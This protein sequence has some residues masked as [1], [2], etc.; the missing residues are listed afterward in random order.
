[1]AKGRILSATISESEKVADL[2][3]D[4]ARLLYTWLQPHADDLG[5][6]PRSARTIKAKVFPMRDDVTIDQVE[7]YLQAMIHGEG[8]HL[9][10]EH[11]I[12]GKQFLRILGFWEHQKLRKDRCPMTIIPNNLTGDSK[13][14]WDQAEALIRTLYTT[15]TKQVVTQLDTNGMS[16]VNHTD[17]TDNNLTQ[18]I[19]EV[20]GIEVNTS[21]VNLISAQKKFCAED[22]KQEEEPEHIRR[23]REFA[24]Q[25][26]EEQVFN[27]VVEKFGSD[28]RAYG[29]KSWLELIASGTFGE[30]EGGYQTSGYMPVG[31]RI[32]RGKVGV[33][34]ADGRIFYFSKN[35]IYK[36]A[37]TTSEKQRGMDLLRKTANGLKTTPGSSP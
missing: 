4:T 17:T 30:F 12:D 23:G 36:A 3:N 13:E 22:E 28:I 1:M 16:V 19:S 27:R 2:P 29:K 6:L 9:L 20:K 26:T 15:K 8:T 37:T 33:E 24:S 18:K 14:Q 32:P 11:E 31:T 25:L 5:F 21:E 10:S 7:E 35:E 34:L